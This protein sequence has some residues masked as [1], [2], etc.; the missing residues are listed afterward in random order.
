MTALQ[1][2]WFGLLGVL[3]AGYA[4]LDG[5]DLGV[6]TLHLLARGDHERRSMLNAIGPVW[7]GNEVWLVVFGG[8]LFAAFPAA[9]AAVFSALYLPLMFLL[10]A[11][12]L[13]AVAIEFRSKHESPR[14]R[15]TWDGVFFFASSASALVFGVAVGN[16]LRGLPLD[17]QGNYTGTTLDLV[18]PFTLLVGA[19][20]VALF[21]LHG[22][23]YLLLK[24]EGALHVRVRRWVWTAAGCFFV[25][26]FLTTVV[27][28]TTVPRA[29]ANFV[30]SPWAWAVVVVNVL[31]A[32]NAPRAAY[33][34]RDLQA[35]ASSAVTIVC[36]VVL[37][38]I[39]QF[40]NLVAGRP[41][42]SRS[43][44]IA[45]G[46]SSDGTLK[47]MLTVVLIGMPFVLA[48]TGIIYWLFRG[49]VKVTKDSY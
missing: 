15:G 33:R 6:G 13:R 11:L 34:N 49:R 46:A 28:L 43:V 44:T 25:L 10:F 8:A 41:D 2:T 22:A 24:T 16:L 1:L 31:A 32:A 27:A 14:W 40:P 26:Y 21:A 17:E 23:N 48:Y 42:P 37:F 9:Y 36:L 47:V 35:F 5:F 3:L 39:A 29:T 7:D 20:A 30:A 38:G 18:S 12:V 19:L 4:V 45:T